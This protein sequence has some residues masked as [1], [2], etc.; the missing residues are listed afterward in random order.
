VNAHPQPLS[1]VSWQDFFLLRPQVFEFGFLCVDELQQ[2]LLARP[3]VV[4]WQGN[5]YHAWSR[6]QQRSRSLRTNATYTHTFAC[7]FVCLFVC[8]AIVDHQVLFTERWRDAS[9]RPRQ[10]EEWRKTG[11]WHAPREAS[12]SPLSGWLDLHLF[13]WTCCGHN[14]PCC[15]HSLSYGLCCICVFHTAWI[16]VDGSVGRSAPHLQLEGQPLPA[17]H[18]RPQFFHPVHHLTYK[19]WLLHVYLARERDRE[20][21]CSRASAAFSTLVRSMI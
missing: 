17:S 15:P 18:R 6:H 10:P 11:A 1:G 9:S 8:L 5:A 21:R 16:G 4:L 3:I 13:D 19:C 2:V 12:H 14:L 20:P 7:L